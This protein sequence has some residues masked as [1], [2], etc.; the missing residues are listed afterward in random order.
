MAC[1]KRETLTE[2][3]C[4]MPTLY[5]HNDAMH[6]IKSGEQISGGLEIMLQGN[7]AVFGASA[8]EGHN[9]LSVLKRTI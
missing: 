3:V 5:I 6:L 8:K 1:C 2:Q 9:I 7:H 4:V